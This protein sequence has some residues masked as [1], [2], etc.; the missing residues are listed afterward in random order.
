[1]NFIV[2]IEKK[3]VRRPLVKIGMNSDISGRLLLYNRA[4]HM[5]NEISVIQEKSQTW[6]YVTMFCDILDETVGIIVSATV[7]FFIN[8][9]AQSE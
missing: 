8:I 3:L 1:M 7:R 6:H 5:M 9:K 4:V 2:L